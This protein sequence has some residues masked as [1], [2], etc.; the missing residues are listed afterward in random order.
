MVVHSSSG[1]V[2]TFSPYT[3]VWRNRVDL[4]DVDSLIA[5]GL[6]RALTGLN[7]PYA[8]L[9]EAKGR[10]FSYAHP[11]TLPPPSLLYPTIS[12]TTFLIFFIT[13]SPR[14]IGPYMDPRRPSL[15]PLRI[16]TPRSQARHSPRCIGSSISSHHPCLSVP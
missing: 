12:S 7:A 10:D 15:L 6:T 13:S 9:Q 1:M 16:P 4:T 8:Q 5:E 11:S 3:H 2:A 14:H